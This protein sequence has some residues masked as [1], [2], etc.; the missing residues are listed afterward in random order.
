MR[1]TQ[2]LITNL[3]ANTK[4]VLSGLSSDDVAYIIKKANEAYHSKA[5]PFITDDVFD[6]I[7]DHLASL[8]PN[9][10]AVAEVGALPTSGKKVT[11]PYYM[12]SMD[13]IKTDDRALDSFQ[14]K[15]QGSYVVT[16]KL[17]GISAL[18]HVNSTR[19]QVC[20]YTRGDGTTGQ[21]IT[22]LLKYISGCPPTAELLNLAASQPNHEFT[23]RGELILTKADFETVKTRGAN[24]RNMVAGIV[25]AKKPDTSIAK[26]IKF[27]AYTLISPATFKPSEGYAYLNAHGFNVVYNTLVMS[28]VSFDSLSKILLK[29]RSESAFEIDGLVVSH[30]KAYPVEVG[31][32]P[33]HAF[34]FKNMVT[35]ETA[36]VIVTNVE[37]NA[38]KD[39]YLVPVIEFDP[40]HISGVMIKRASGFNG[41]YI[42]SNVI[43]PGARIII[44]RSG[45]VIPY[46]LQVLSP[47]AQPQMPSEPYTWTESGKDIYLENASSNKQVQLKQLENFFTKLNVAGMKAGTITK[48]FEAGLDDIQKII[49]APVSTIAK[50][51]GF[52]S[53]SAE[54]IV[55]AIKEKLRTLSC[56]ELMDASNAFGRGFGSKRLSAIMSA[57]PKIADD[58]TMPTKAELVAVDGVSDKTAEAFMKGLTTYRDFK[59]S[60]NISC[61][62]PS[63]KR[64][65]PNSPP[66][67][68]Q[69]DATPPKNTGGPSKT[70][71]NT[72]N[73]F[74][75][76]VV[77]FTGFRDA[78]I[79]ALIEDEGGEV[80]DTVTKKTTI[81]VAK[82][83]D[84]AT[85]KIEKARAN[86][87]Q[88]FS[89]AEFKD[90][91]HI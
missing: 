67:V 6:I 76:Q 91:F 40:V 43:G 68:V 51:D 66:V 42:K 36:E 19:K 23:V 4:A 12:G 48:L 78:S 89:I 82:D 90:T 58:Q 27:M 47:A 77:V 14:K 11:L 29:R 60:L 73:R 80:G 22:H 37:W 30:D 49:K 17:D 74:M 35:Q 81:L 1:I 41:E 72:T 63:P 2:K 45:E 56:I 53:K 24:A 13:K 52:Q 88:V 34:A 65:K 55:E 21:D 50:I 28:T 20:L 38:S 64:A 7:K 25:N 85:G 5:G 18:L 15:Y 26:L 62:G 70:T 83:L 46:V 9:H 33:S 87:V 75:N 57:I 61:S 86:G 32:N 84:K 71:K 8:Q 44:T 31:K 54:K 10:Q 3:K 59:R 39:G 69:S 16:D 79:K